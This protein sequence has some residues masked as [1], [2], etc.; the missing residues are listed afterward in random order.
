MD[1]K[2]ISKFGCAVS[3]LLIASAMPASV[4]AQGRATTEFNGAPFRSAGA[5]PTGRVLVRW[6]QQVRTS[7]TATRSAKASRIAGVAF[8]STPRSGDSI[9]ALEPAEP[10][11]PADLERAVARLE[12]AAEVELAS[13]E[14]RRRLHALTN[15]PLLTQQWYLLSE[16]AAAT[17]SDIAWDVTHGSDAIV[18]AVLDTGVRPEHPDLQGKLLPGY[19]FISNTL[20]S[21]DGDGRDSDPTDP[22]DWVTRQE[23]DQH[24]NDVLDQ[25]C[26]NDGQDVRSS[27]HG[28]RVAGLI[29]AHTNN[30]VGIAGMAWH[31]RI[32]PVRVMGKCG[33]NDF[34]I[35]QAMR[36]AAGITVDGL[37]N[38][39]PAQVINLSLGG[40]G[41]CTSL[42]QATV[43]E[44]NARGVLV[45]ASA[46]N[47]GQGVSS[48]ANCE[49]V[50]GV[51]GLRHAGTKVGFSNLG[52]QVGIAAPGGNCVNLVGPCLFSI[53][54]A[55]NTGSTTPL[56]SSYTDQLNFNVG[57]SFSAPMVAGAAALLHAVNG[58]LT[59]EQTM[60]LLRASTT[61]FPLLSGVPMCRVPA[62]DVG[63]QDAECN[64]TTS[65]C[66]A[67]MLNTG[68]A[69]AA[70]LQP[71]AVIRTT[72]TVAAG[73]TLSI[74]GSQSFASRART[75]AA[76]Q[77]SVTDVVGAAPTIANTSSASTTLQLPLE[78]QFTLQLT[79]TDDQGAQDTRGTAIFIAAAPSPPPLPQPPPP[80]PINSGGG[81][82]GSWSWLLMALL[83]LRVRCR[84]SALAA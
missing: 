17:R 59:P 80:A 48:P 50:L 31:T 71:L 14:Y 20:I 67:G 61:Q 25:D 7:T 84:R 40:D 56:A 18:V 42:Y 13:L 32:L 75:I 78:G 51:A 74:D 82:G 44:L 53:V 58:S 62:P 34:D 9:E 55:T 60:H 30:A 76:H 5:Q 70:A 11:S 21:N 16:Q 79:V 1:A 12:A 65:T 81:G 29:G 46:G 24:S 39:H 35:M 3:L 45:V 54:V 36:W 49:G 68:A 77:W 41:P 2:W 72:G 38:P 69:V 43:N 73:A 19:D 33:G 28:T 57:T 52:P 15:D 26:L 64:C 27:W 47:E 22:G 4:Y 37:T 23:V 66:G 63:V 8:K 83:L 10:L 6:N